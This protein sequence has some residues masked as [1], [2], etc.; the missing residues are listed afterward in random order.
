MLDRVPID[1]NRDLCLD[2][3]GKWNILE[4]CMYAM[5]LETMGRVK[6]EF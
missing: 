5:H 4:G 3:A 2:E 6:H 1:E